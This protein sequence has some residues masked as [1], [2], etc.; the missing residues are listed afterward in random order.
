MQLSTPDRAEEERANQVLLTDAIT[1]LQ[2]ALA[3]HFMTDE[4]LDAALNMGRSS[5]SLGPLD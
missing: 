3:G 1:G 2:E 5:A 4:Q